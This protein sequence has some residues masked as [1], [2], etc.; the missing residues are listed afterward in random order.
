MQPKP[1][2]LDNKIFPICCLGSVPWK[3]PRSWPSSLA[4]SLSKRHWQNRDFTCLKGNYWQGN[5]LDPNEHRLISV[6]GYMRWFPFPLRARS[7][8]GL[9]SAA[10]PLVMLP[11]GFLHR[12][13]GRG[14]RSGGVVPYLQHWLWFWTILTHEQL[15]S[16]NSLNSPPEKLECPRPAEPTT[17][18]SDPLARNASALWLYSSKPLQPH[19]Y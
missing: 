19:R 9:T 1:T 8:M 12:G 11:A 5:N 7:L 6:W 10:G 2:A 15:L 4:A 13:V 3:K 17:W 16:A 14:C 18:L